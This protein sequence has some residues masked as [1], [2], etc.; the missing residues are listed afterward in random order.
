MKF[1][2]RLV[3]AASMCLAGQPLLAAD[4]ILI[5]EKRTA[6]GGTG[7]S[8]IQIE[9]T[10]IRAE[11]VDPNGGRQAFVF[12]GGTE[13]LR[14]IDY[15]KKTYVEMTKADMDR[16]G[17]QVAGMMA[18]M[19][20]KLKSL[21]PAQRA[22][23]EAMMKGRGMNLAA[24]GTQYR[25]AGAGKVGKWSCDRY[26][27]YQNDQKISEVCTVAP[28]VLG[29]TDDDIQVTQQLTAFLRALMPEN[30]DQMF[31][32]GKSDPQGFS[33]VPVRRSYS[34]LGRPAVTELTDVSRQTFAD[35]IFEVPEG[36]QKQ[37]LGMPGR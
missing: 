16:L 1:T 9:K 34:V 14:I 19:Q 31:S 6:A 18:Q 27:G 35:S 32:L 11:S 10:R 12:D 17:G 25:K 7:T 28:A 2:V 23:M 36:F 22:Q 33:G 21:P 13:R 5:V 24:V 8:Q 29:I 15:G 37:A 26:E 30:A 3:L 20:E 4:G